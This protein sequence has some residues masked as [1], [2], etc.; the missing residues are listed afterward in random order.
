MTFFSIEE[1]IFTFIYDRGNELNIKF[2]ESENGLNLRSLLHPYNS[3][4]LN[5]FLLCTQLIK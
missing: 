1:N 3:P 2:D 5:A 4:F